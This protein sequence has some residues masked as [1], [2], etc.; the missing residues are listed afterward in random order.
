MKQYEDMSFDELLAYKE[1]LISNDVWITLDTE[2][3]REI[4]SL[5]EM[6]YSLKTIRTEK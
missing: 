4:N 1:K 5:L 3:K 2:E 6:K